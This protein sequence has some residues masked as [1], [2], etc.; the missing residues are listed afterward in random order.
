MTLVTLTTVPIVLISVY[1]ESRYID[2][3]DMHEKQAIERS[4]RIAVEAI[5][6]IRTVQSLG[7]EKFVLERYNQEI[8][9]S[10][11]PSKKKVRF[12]GTVFSLGQ[13]IPTL[14]YGIGLYYGGYLV[15]TTDLEYKN[16]IKLV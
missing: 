12:R 13:T 2:Y 3:S 11:V 7:Q 16:V 1:L 15:A 14:A 4:S 10:S 6:S 5:T 9:N 8:E